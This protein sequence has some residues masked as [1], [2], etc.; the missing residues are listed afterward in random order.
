MLCQKTFIV[1]EV[2]RLSEAASF[3]SSSW[4]EA[5]E[6]ISVH[7]PKGSSWYGNIKDF[8]NVA[9]QLFH[10]AFRSNG[11]VLFL[12]PG[13]EDTLCEVSS[14]QST[15]LILLPNSLGK[16]VI[17]VPC[18]QAIR[19]SSEWDSISPVCTNA[20]TATFMIWDSAL[21]S[22]WIAPSYTQVEKQLTFDQSFVRYECFHFHTFKVGMPFDSLNSFL[23]PES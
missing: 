8:R 18:F 12:K 20:S 9:V 11:A 3:I 5:S 17:L 4:L 13:F 23:S 7:L 1:R 10:C 19:W 16:R 15:A 6:E 2:Y 14:R 21:L 22:S